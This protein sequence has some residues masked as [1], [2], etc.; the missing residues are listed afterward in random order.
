MKKTVNVNIGSVAFVMDEDAYQTLNNYYEDIRSRLYESEKTDTMDD[1]ES[2]T[3]DIFRENL[4]SPVQV[5]NIDLVRR[6]IAIIGSA[7]SF[8]ERRYDPNYEPPREQSRPG[9][10]YRS[11]TNTVIAGVCGGLAEYFGTDVS[12]IRVL[13]FI[14][15]FI[16]VSITFWA[17]VIMWI[18]VPLAPEAG[19]TGDNYQTRGGM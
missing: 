4:A 5:V 11:R 16:S 8:G 3:A 7:Q 10:L 9:K 18:V 6:A 12:L 2:R 13:V 14:S 15:F 1:I 19:N 17:Y